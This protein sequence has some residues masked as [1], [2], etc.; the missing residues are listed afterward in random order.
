M[1]DIEKDLLEYVKILAILWDED[2]KTVCR[3]AC[4]ALKISSLRDNVQGQKLAICYFKSI[5][6]D[7]K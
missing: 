4:R 6:E 3:K 2:E 7:K 5:L 1:T